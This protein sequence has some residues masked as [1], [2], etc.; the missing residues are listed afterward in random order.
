MVYEGT[1]HPGVGSIVNLSNARVAKILEAGV[2]MVVAE[3]AG[4]PAPFAPP[5]VIV[6]VVDAGNLQSHLELTLELSQ[7]GRPMV[8]AVNRMDEAAEKGLYINVKALE[9]MLGMPV[10]PT[11]ALMGH[12][13]AE[14]F[15]GAVDAA[16]G[17]S[18][19]LPQSPSPI[20]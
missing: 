19:P 18:C 13:I 14:L 17:D 12:G 10:V 11:V 16:R 6:Q 1:G 4:P 5:D 20:G 8:L 15:R 9:Q 7:L 2:I 3:K